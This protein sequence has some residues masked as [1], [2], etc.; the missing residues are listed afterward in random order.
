[1]G[2]RGKPPWWDGELVR[3]ET[4][5]LERMRVQLV[6]NLTDE[7]HECDHGRLPLDRNKPV[8]CDCWPNEATNALASRV[9]DNPDFCQG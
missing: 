5:A 2:R 4:A 1:M 3:R 9:Q 6:I 7:A 8:E